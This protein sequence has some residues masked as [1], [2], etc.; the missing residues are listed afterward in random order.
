MAP[1]NQ[2]ERRVKD[3]TKALLAVAAR[4]T[5]AVIRFCLYVLLLLFGR[6]LLPVT[7]I[8]TVIGTMVFLF[9]ALLR[10]DLQIPMW[11][12]AGLAIAATVVSVFYDAALR[13]VAPEG[14]AIV[15]DV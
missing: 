1:A 3:S 13:L 8:A 2:N 12:G 15:R 5:L 11:S 6:I 14:T 9:C 10:R 7:G 4:S